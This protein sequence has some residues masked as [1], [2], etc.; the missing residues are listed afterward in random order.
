MDRLADVISFCFLWFRFL[1]FPAWLIFLG[2][3]SA[4]PSGPPPPYEEACHSSPLGRPSSPRRTFFDRFPGAA[5]LLF[6]LRADPGRP[7]DEQPWVG[8]LH[9]KTPSV[10]RLMREGF[11]VSEANVVR[12]DNFLSRT[13][14]NPLPANAEA[15]RRRCRRYGFTRHYILRDVREPPGW[16]AHL[17]CMARELLPG[18]GRI[19]LGDLTHRNVHVCVA[20]QPDGRRTIYYFEAGRGGINVL[21]GETPLEGLWPW[22]RRLEDAAPGD[23]SHPPEPNKPEEG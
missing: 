3:I 9:V 20:T 13:A 2:S 15:R 18:L 12:E 11:A 7:D 16:A 22:P 14:D 10:A 17:F 4:M 21:Y 23:A 5:V 19:R 8:E 1:V 6:H